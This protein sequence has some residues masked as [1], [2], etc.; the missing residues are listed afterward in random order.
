METT[1]FPHRP[2]ERLC[3]DLA[4]LAVLSSVAPDLRLPPEALLP[5]C[6]CRRAAVWLAVVISGCQSL[7]FASLEPAAQPT[8]T[9]ASEVAPTSAPA[10]TSDSPKATTA[11]A[12]PSTTRPGVAVDQFLVNNFRQ[13]LDQNEWQVDVAWS[14]VGD[15]AKCPNRPWRSTFVA[16]SS[17]VDKERAGKTALPPGAERWDWIWHG[18]AAG[19][20]A[21]DREAGI[22]IL[23]SLQGEADRTAR[24]AAILLVRLQPEQPAPVRETLRRIAAGELKGDSIKINDS[25]SIKELPVATRCAA[26]EAWC[27]S[28]SVGDGDLET[29]LTPAGALLNLPGLAE[30]LQGTLWRSLARHIDPDRLP[31]L[32]LALSRK[33]PQRSSRGQQLAAL[34]ACVIAAAS[35]R[36]TQAADATVAFDDSDWPAGLLAARLDE[37]PLMRQLIARWA[38][39]AQHPE[40]MTLLTAQSRDVDPAVRDAAIVSMGVLRTPAAL[41]HLQILARGS[42][43]R[44]QLM[45]VSALAQWGDVEI[46]RYATSPA[47]AVRG[48]VARGLGR[49]PTAEARSLLRRLLSDSSPTVQLEAVAA[50]SRHSAESAVPLLL[51]AVESSEFGARKAAQQ[52]LFDQL[53]DPPLLPIEGTAVERRDAVRVWAATHGYALEPWVDDLQ[54]GSIAPSTSENTELTRLLQ[55]LMLLES[56]GPESAALLGRLQSSITTADVAAV[57]ATFAQ[58]RRPMV[59]TLQRELLPKVSADYAALL[60]LESSDI[61]QRRAAARRI[62]QQSVERPLTPEFVRCLGDVLAR[63]QDQLVWQACLASVQADGHDAAGQLALLALN[64]SWPDLRRMGAEHFL[65]HPAPEAIPALMPLLQDPQPSVQL[66]AVRALGAAGNPWAITGFPAGEGTGISIGLRSLMNSRNDEVRWAALTALASLRDETAVVELLR[67]IQDSQPPVRMRAVQAMGRSGYGRFIEPLIRLSWTES[68]D[69]VK[70]DILEALS[71][72]V[73]VEQQPT[74][75][76]GLV[77]AASIDDK[78][79]G[80]VA[81][82]DASRLRST[83]SPRND[84]AEGIR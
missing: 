64:H 7:D 51:A 8:S 10:A 78:I 16:S 66:A 44:A 52:A 35:R 75:P 40:A 37:A 79:H 72:L 57:E 70:R 56:T 33:Q 22:Q 47:P 82:W 46:A 81:W 6:R 4:E 67:L 23:T 32:S 13:W 12:E 77:A 26:A 24:N 15:E 3:S 42:D 59:R 45:A 17:A 25:L 19:I 27:H 83:A 53:N 31:Q 55:E 41:Q 29:R 74:F 49:I 73:P 28:L 43:E 9:A 60:E 20:A 68:S 39:W 30:E 58:G 84:G 71:A 76:S 80:W 63:E 50:A 21:S 54:T 65:R 36:M 18:D 61:Q 11:D 48:M 14:V 1:V 62:R 69:S 38:A 5:R 34:E 2:S